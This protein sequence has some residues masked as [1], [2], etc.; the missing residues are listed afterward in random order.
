MI[1]RVNLMHEEK[2]PN[3]AQY[4]IIYINGIPMFKIKTH[5]S[6]LTFIQHKIG[7]STGKSVPGEYYFEV[8]PKPSETSESPKPILIEDYTE[9]HEDNYDI[10]SNE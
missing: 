4:T 6:D 3:K 1:I 10:W 2:K 8:D 5:S 7:N 9:P